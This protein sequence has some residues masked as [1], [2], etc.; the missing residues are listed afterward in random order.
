MNIGKGATKLN[1]KDI[2]NMKVTRQD[3]L[4]ALGEVSPAFGVNEEDLKTCLEGGIIKYSP[5]L[6]KY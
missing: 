5:K 3:F 4:D 1:N 2:A 6:M